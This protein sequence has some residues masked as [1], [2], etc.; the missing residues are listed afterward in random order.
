M[1]SYIKQVLNR[2]IKIIFSPLN[3]RNKFA[4]LGHYKNNLSLMILFLSPMFLLKLFCSNRT[5]NNWKYTQKRFHKKNANILILM[6]W[7]RLKENKMASTEVSLLNY[8]NA[9]NRE[10][11][12]FNPIFKNITQYFFKIKEL[13]SGKKIIWLQRLLL[14]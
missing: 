13:Y 4:F 2:T 12:A 8:Q 10:L 3:S 5:N 7:K 9:F 6:I 11:I 14:I 1:N